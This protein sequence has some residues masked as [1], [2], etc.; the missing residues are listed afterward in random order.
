MSKRL[1]DAAARRSA[2]G[3]L[4]LRQSLRCFFDAAVA[5]A[6]AAVAVVV[7]A[8]APRLL[9]LLFLVSPLPVC[10]AAAAFQAPAA[11][12]VVTAAQL[13]LP[14][15]A[16]A[17]GVAAAAAAGIAAVAPPPAVSAAAAA[18]PRDRVLLLG[19]RCLQQQGHN[20][21]TA[22]AA[23]EQQQQQ[24]T[25][26]VSAMSCM[27]SFSACSCSRCCCCSLY[28][29][30]SSCCCCWS[31]RYCCSCCCSRCSAVCSCCCSVAASADRSPLSRCC[32]NCSACRSSNTK[33]TK[34][35]E[36]KPQE[37]RPR[38]HCSSNSSSKSRKAP[39]AFLVFCCSSRKCSSYYCY[40]DQCCCDCW[41][42][43]LLQ[44]AAAPALQQVP[45]VAHLSAQR[46]APTG[47]VGLHPEGQETVFVALG[48]AAAAAAAIAAASASA[49][50][51]LRTYF[52][53]S[54]LALETGD[55]LIFAPQL[56]L[57]LLVLLQLSLLPLAFSWRELG[58]RRSCSA[59]RD[60]LLQQ[61]PAG[62]AAF[63]QQPRQLRQQQLHHGHDNKVQQ[64]FLLH[65]EG[66][67]SLPAARVDV[68]SSAAAATP[69]CRGFGCGT[70]ASS[71]REAVSNKEGRVSLCGNRN[72]RG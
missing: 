35:Q 39:R 51:G 38:Q 69:C 22:T 31:L 36:R 11:P 40:R 48:F 49:A 68:V 12:A 62:V 32:C 37:L 1:P 70:A 8:A 10:Y 44:Q 41:C 34:Q 66:R 67:W 58:S 23:R 6:A 47:P 45:C 42:R 59:R 65:T 63:K 27:P 26:Y 24:Y 52:H 57:L 30:C 9:L 14:A 53:E 17:A 2:H 71:S 55:Q 54:Y 60:Q 21:A 3:G 25:L 28:F 64:P 43:C 72:T 50:A 15:S 46:V 61:I 29:C 16:A 4:Q 5:A 18:T 33:G 56:F 7:A 20:T 19:R 13:A